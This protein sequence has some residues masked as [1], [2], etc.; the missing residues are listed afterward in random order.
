[1]LH[2]ILNPWC[3][4]LLTLRDINVIL[5]AISSSVTVNMIY[6][7]VSPTLVRCDSFLIDRF[8][9]RISRSKFF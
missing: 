7:D 8:N 6:Y 3:A 2:V 5:C 1:M 4:L 9:L